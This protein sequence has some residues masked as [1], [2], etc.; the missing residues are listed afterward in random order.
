MLTAAFFYIL[1]STIACIGASLEMVIAGKC[2]FG[3]GI[4]FAM[5]SAPG[6]FVRLFVCEGIFCLQV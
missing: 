2:I 1:G 5:H 6:S 4:G 3:L